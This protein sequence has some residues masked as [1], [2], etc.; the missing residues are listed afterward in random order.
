[1]SADPDIITNELIKCLNVQDKETQLRK[2]TNVYVHKTDIIQYTEKVNKNVF[3]M[4]IS[5][6]PLLCG[7]TMKKN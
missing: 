2:F 1:M 4:T 6:A 5:S 7:I 3:K